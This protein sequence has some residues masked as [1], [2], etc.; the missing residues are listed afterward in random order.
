MFKLSHAV[1]R[2]HL[3]TIAQAVAANRLPGEIM[4]EVRDCWRKIIRC[5]SRGKKTWK[6]SIT[7]DMKNEDDWVR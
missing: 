5:R 4:S 2:L 3:G 6:D 1:I 7:D